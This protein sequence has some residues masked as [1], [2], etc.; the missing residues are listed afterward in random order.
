[1]KIDFHVHTKYSI[2]SLSEPRDIANLCKKA[3]VVPAITD[4]NSMRAHADFR[5][6]GIPFIPAEEISTDRGDLIGLF[7][8]EPIAKRTPFMEALDAIKSQGGLS[9]LP[10]MYDVSR[11]GVGEENLAAMADI[12]ETFN[13]RCVM[14]GANKKAGEFAEKHGKLKAA[15]SDAHFLVEVGKTYAEMPDC[16]L[17]P[18]TLLKAIKK[19]KLIC[20]PAPVYLKG[21]TYAAIAYKKI[22][23]E[24]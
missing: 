2:D 10:H 5:A 14:P 17:E 11:N 12:I 19:A 24:P 15:G 4:H 3:G 16:E 18:K 6:L 8:S 9:Y 13:A 23:G 7:I 21:L 20:H 1:M 22:F